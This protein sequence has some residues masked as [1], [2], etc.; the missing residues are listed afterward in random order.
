MLEDGT[1]DCIV[2]RLKG[3]QFV[4]LFVENYPVTTNVS[5]FA[6]ATNIGIAAQGDIILTSQIPLDGTPDEDRDGWDTRPYSSF[7]QV[8]EDTIRKIPLTKEELFGAFLYKDHL[9][10][11][12]VNDG[13]YYM[14]LSTGQEVKI[15]DAAYENAYGHC[16]DGKY[17]IESTLSVPGY[18]SAATEPRMRYFDGE[19]WH[20]L[21]LPDYWNTGYGLRVVAGT[22]DRI[23]FTVDDDAESYGDR[24]QELCCL[25]FG[26]DS[27]TV[28]D[29]YPCSLSFD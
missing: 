4:N 25:V 12:R 9:C 13:F 22:S 27:F 19:T 29:K 17:M 6:T 10:F 8:T 3:E 28:C 20:E 2:S 18:S 21:E 7:Y 14:D 26:E 16:V 24:Q 1:W 15:A 11:Y 5:C 23:F